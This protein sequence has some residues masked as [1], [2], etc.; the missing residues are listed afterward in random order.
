MREFWDERADEDAFFFVDSR[1]SYRGSDRDR[2]WASG[3]ADLNAILSSLDV[4][5]SPEDEVVEIGCGVGRLT[6]PLAARGRTVHAFDVSGRM[7]E[8]A[9]RHNPQLENVT[10][11]RGDGASLAGVSDASIDVC[12][13]HVVFQ[14]IPDPG[15]TLGYV[16]EMGRVLRPGGWSA[17]QVSNQPTIH[18]RRPLATR[19]RTLPGRAMRKRPRGQGHAAWLGSSIDLDRLRLVAAEAG[20]QLDRVTGAETQWCAVLARKPAVETAAAARRRG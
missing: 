3:P 12:F 19:L 4:R 18:Q 13:S 5:I 17:F 16:R 8:L 1:E 7:L 9:R 20:M 10:W 11:I 14:H 15:V 2:F 6:R